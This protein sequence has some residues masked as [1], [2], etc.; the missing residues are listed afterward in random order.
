MI[1]D[2]LTP[3]ELVQRCIR[4][5]SVEAWEAFVRRFQGVIAAS[6]A[7]T[8]RR[9]GRVSHGV[10]D[11][12]VQE[13][14]LRLCAQDCRA[15]RGFQARSEESIFGFLKVVAANVVNDHMR[16]ATAEKR[17]DGLSHVSL[18]DADPR[19]RSDRHHLDRS[20]LLREVEQCLNQC[21]PGPESQRDRAIFWLYYRQGLSAQAIASLPELG[22]GTKGVES[23]LLRLTRLVRQRLS[24]PAQRQG[25]LRRT[26]G[27]EGVL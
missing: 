19:A 5:Q 1:Y 2:R 17:G 24:A 8:A 20:V 25:A 18:E 7:R 6:V 16:A 22:L 10:V 26:A 23:L 15:L 9:W 12:L 11:D 13:T 3:D 27:E 21:L 14:Y 4:E